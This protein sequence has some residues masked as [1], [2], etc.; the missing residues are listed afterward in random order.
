[1]AVATVNAA[2]ESSV[3]CT[4]LYLSDAELFVA[5]IGDVLKD[6]GYPLL[7]HLMLWKLVHP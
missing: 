6:E 1:M 5:T 3:L 4:E 2:G 7:W